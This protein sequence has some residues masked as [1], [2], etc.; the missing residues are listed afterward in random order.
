MALGV[1]VRETHHQGQVHFGPF[2]LWPLPIFDGT[3]ECQ[4]DPDN[5]QYVFLLGL[6][7]EDSK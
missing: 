1:T 3:D 4:A 7:L 5:V 2:G 6:L